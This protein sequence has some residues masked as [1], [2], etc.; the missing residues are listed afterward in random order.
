[1]C[2]IDSPFS[3]SALLPPPKSQDRFALLS[4]YLFAVFKRKSVV[5]TTSQETWR[6]QKRGKNEG[7]KDLDVIHHSR[8]CIKKK[9]KKKI[10][11]IQI[12]GQGESK[13]RWWLHNIPYLFFVVRSVMLAADR[14]DKKDS[15]LSTPEIWL[16]ND[17]RDNKW[18]WFDL[19]LIFA[20]RS[21]W[22]PF[23]VDLSQQISEWR[24]SLAKKTNKQNRKTF[25]IRFPAR[26]CS[27]PPIVQP[28]LFSF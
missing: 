25:R 5:G 16:H 10:K 23:A 17:S 3:F 8:W 20:E 4:P 1:M 21:R 7:K 9:Y 24:I 2:V 15:Q 14:G 27:I 28:F 12:L 22:N 11:R 6:Y 18:P 26:H 19:K 13:D